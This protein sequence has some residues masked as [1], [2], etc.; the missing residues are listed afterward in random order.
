MVT[1]ITAYKRRSQMNNTTVYVG[2]DVHKESFTLCAYTL[3]K[4]KGSYSRRTPADYKEVLK[5][6]EFLRT[7]YGND[8]IF[9]CGYEAGCLGYT[10]YHQLTDHHVDC[11]ILAPTTMLE[12]RGKKRIKTD[13]RDAEIIGKCLAQHN[14]SPVHVPTASDEEVKEFL[15][16]RDDHKLALK[17]VKQ[18]ILAFCLRHNYRFDGNSHWTAAHINWLKSLTPE[19]LYKEILDEYLLTYTILSDKLERLD[20][21][22]EEL[23]AKAEYKEA[24]K[25]LCCFIG[26]KTHTALSVIVEVGDF[27]RFASAEKFASYIGLVP[28][29]D[30]SGDGQTR[31]GITKAGNRH[32]RMLL[33]EASQCY[34]RGQIG[35]KSKALKARQDGNTPQVIAYADKANERLRR[36]YYKMVLSKCKKHNV[37]KT[38]IARELACFMWGMMTD[39]IA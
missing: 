8:T 9:V 12:Q 33:T 14:Y 13:K 15:R 39:N 6:L 3:E 34:S 23:A 26:V 21:R 11:V 18:Q 38:A 31:L 27:K 20:K 37:A 4:E 35:Y 25:K 1:G 29:E 19:A 7:V 22:I 2:M 32:V 28:G 5:Y 24:V 36:R 16:M 10:L 30:S 17:K